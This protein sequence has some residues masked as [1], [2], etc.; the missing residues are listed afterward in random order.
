MTCAMTRCH[1]GAPAPRPIEDCTAQKVRMDIRVAVTGA[2]GTLGRAAV[3]HLLGAGYEVRAIDRT[4]PRTP[5]C[6]F[7]MVD[8][9]DLGQVCG[10]LAGCDAV[11]HLAALPS[12]VGHPQEAAF[13]I[14]AFGTFNRMEAA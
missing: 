7:C 11:L 6:P 9:R 5:S 2:S 10:A 8:I 12:P 13:S 3:S 1:A 4:P 14:N